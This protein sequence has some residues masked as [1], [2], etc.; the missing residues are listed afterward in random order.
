MD[1]II[2]DIPF[3]K[4]DFL[5]ISWMRWRIEWHKTIKRIKNSSIA[6]LIILILGIIAASDDEPFNPF[7]L[8]G[9]GL[10]II[11][12]FVFSIMFFSKKQYKSKVNK[13]AERYEKLK[14]DASY[15]IS[16]DYFKYQDSEKTVDF[17]WNT[18]SGY[19]FYKN[20][21]IVK[22]HN[23]SLANSFIFE[24]DESNIEDYHR[25][26]DLV[27]AKLDYIEMS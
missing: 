22:L 25:V 2:L 10:M 11:P 5:R 20:L 13:L 14:M 23:A 1:I 24:K 15:E 6:G 21:L 26:L 19:S 17:K 18:F 12:I 8:I 4:E 7:I 16:P 3:K 9:I 27:K